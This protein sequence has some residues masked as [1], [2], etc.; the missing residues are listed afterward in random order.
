MRGFLRTLDLDSFH[1]LAREDDPLDFVG[2]IMEPFTLFT[3]ELRKVGTGIQAASLRTCTLSAIPANCNTAPP[4]KL[5][6]LPHAVRC[7]P[8]LSSD[9]AFTTCTHYCVHAFNVALCL[10]RNAV[11]WSSQCA[12]N[13]RAR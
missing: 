12:F 9:P 13:D 5:A 2:M 3:A 1:G 10:Y 4:T 11:L 7:E 8:S 6:Y